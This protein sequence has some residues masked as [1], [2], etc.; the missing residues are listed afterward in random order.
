MDPRQLSHAVMCTMCTVNDPRLGTILSK[1]FVCSPFSLQGCY[2]V[3]AYPTREIACLGHRF[4]DIDGPCAMDGSWDADFLAVVETL[5]L[6]IGGM[7]GILRWLLTNRSELLAILVVGSLALPGATARAY[8]L[9]W[10]WATQNCGHCFGWV[11]ATRT[12]R[13]RSLSVRCVVRRCCAVRVV[14]L[15]TAGIAS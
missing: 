9:F 13:S 12:W 7:K 4:L 15:W 11:R 10:S 5:L 6:I 14:L 1:L 2:N 3:T 8:V